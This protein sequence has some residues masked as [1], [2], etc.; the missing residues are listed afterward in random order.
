MRHLAS[1]LYISMASWVVLLSVGM[2]SVG[3]ECA[4]RAVNLSQGQV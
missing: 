1:G 3:F 4:C 2:L